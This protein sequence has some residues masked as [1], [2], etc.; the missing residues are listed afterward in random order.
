MLSFRNPLIQKCALLAL[1]FMFPVMGHAQEP[2]QAQW[3][4]QQCIDYAMANNLE[5]RQKRVSVDQSNVDIE[6]RKGALFPTLS[7]ATNQ[8]AS[9]RPWSESYVN[10][11]D[12]AMASTTSKLNY[13]GTYGLQAQWS[14]WN[15]GINRKQLEQSRVQQT[16]AETDEE[17][18]RLSIQQ[19]IVQVYVQIL[20]QTEAVNVCN[21]IL[22]STRTQLDRA[23]AMYE[24]GNMSRADL[25]QIQS[26]VN[27]EEYNVTNANIQLSE[28]K[29]Q[30]RQ[31]LQLPWDEDFAVVAPTIDDSRI[32]ALL[33]SV[34]DVYNNALTLRPELRYSQLGITSAELAIDI[35]RRGRYP[36]VNLQAGINTSASSGLDFSWAH[37]IKNNLSNSFG[38]TISVPIFDGK[39]IST[40]VARAR[41]DRENAEIA[42]EQQQRALYN[43]IETCWLNATNAQ[44]Q[45]KYALSYA[46]SMLES[47]ALVSEQFEVG[48]KDVVDLTTAKNNLV[49]SQ[50]QLLQSKY[51][52]VL[53]RALLNFYQGYELTLN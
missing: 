18:S 14:V 2:V 26:Q 10:I 41:L 29:K 17:M 28:Y 21:D 3:S 8:N 23:Q 11:T 36:S 45:Y 46:N 32:M 49:Q 42:L 16:Q 38:L 6:A 53:N 24:V 31:L 9:W 30:L 12:G 5:L 19:Q 4:L 7:A 44:D 39:Q 22:E 27:Q 48:L 37:Q 34:A 52:A 47:Y 13:N 15:G 35:A 51:T 33:P 20:Y 43:D 50:Q 25:A 1:A 40:S